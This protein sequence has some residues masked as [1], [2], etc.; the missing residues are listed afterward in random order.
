MLPTP[1]RKVKV[2]N[3]LSRLVRRL[4][5]SHK[6]HVRGL[7][8]LDERQLRD[9]GARAEDVAGMVD[10]DMSALLCRHLWRQGPKSG[11]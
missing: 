5:S 9:I 6:R 1:W 8:V 3:A 10:R 4:F 2:G 7:P 11:S